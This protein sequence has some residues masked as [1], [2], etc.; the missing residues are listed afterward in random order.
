VRSSRGF[1]GAIVILAG[2]PLAFLASIVLGGG[3]SEILHV[4]LGLSFLLFAGSAF[5]FGLPSWMKVVAGA[6]IGALGAIFFLQGV[7]DIARS[8]PLVGFAYG[9][10]GQRLEK[11]LG[12]VFLVWCA[13][14][15]VYV[16]GAARGC[17]ADW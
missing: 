2:V 9:V 12:Y 17:S 14:I 7:A 1:V 4:A 5:D 11:L 15:L 6:A 16:S 13:A 3:A 10:L 8:A